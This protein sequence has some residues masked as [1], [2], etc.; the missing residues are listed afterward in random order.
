LNDSE[1]RLL[2]SATTDH[3]WPLVELFS[4]I[5]REHPDDGNRAATQLIDRLKALGVPVKVYEP[6]LYLALPQ[7]A[8]V[9]CEG[10]QLFAR[11]AP[12]SRPAPD[13]V[14]APPGATVYYQD[15]DSRVGPLTKYTLVD[16]ADA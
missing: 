14:K 13:G 2:A 8:H 3:A 16:H 9:D 12:M 5:R 4:T 10:R 6:Q 15:V 11:P 1:Q 7:G